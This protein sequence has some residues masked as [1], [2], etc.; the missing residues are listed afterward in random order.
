MEEEKD[1]SIYNQDLALE[2]KTFSKKIYNYFYMML[3]DK[4]ETNFLEIYILFIL[5]T[6]QLISYGISEP[7]L[8]V[9]K[10][11]SST[12]KTVSDVVGI[13]RISTLMKYVDF[14][15]YLII[16]FILIA[17]IFIFSVF[18]IMQIFI[19]KEESKIF[20]A[21]VT[22][23]RILI[24]PLYIF[25]F[26]PITE[27]ILLPL[28]C[29][30]EGKIDIIKDGITCWGGMHYL[31]IILGIIAS[32]IFFITIYFLISF[33]FFPFNYNES[34]IRINTENDTFFLIIKLIFALR[35]ILIKNE[36]ISI[37]LLF[38]LSLYNLFEEFFEA[39]FNNFKLGLFVNIRNF[40]AFWTYFSLLIAKLLKNSQINGVIYFFCFGIP[41]TILCCYLLLKNQ[42]A[43]FDYTTS[44]FTTLNEYLNK[45]RFLIQLIDSFIEGSKNIRFG[46]ESSNQKT[47][48]LLK[49]IIKIHTISCIRE[50]CPLTKFIQNPGNYNVQ[51]QCLLNYMTIYFNQGIKK[52]PFSSKLLLFFIQFNFSKRFNLNSVRTNIA[53]VQK[54][55]NTY[56]VDFIIYIL[57][58]DIKN[59]RIQISD[60][61]E[62]NN[63][64]QEMDA[65]T[66]KYRRLKYLIE[67]STKLYGEFWGIFATNIT[68][69]LNTF[70]L[71]NLGQKLNLYLKEINHL[72]DNELKSKKIDSENQGIIQL[73]S[74]FLKEILWNKK[75]SEEITKKLNDEHQHHHDNKKRIEENAQGNN[76]DADLENPDYIIYATSNEKGECTIGQCTNSIINLLG[77][78]KSEIIG[79]KIEVL[80]PKIFAEGHTKMLSDTIKKLHLKQHSQRNS[81][82]E[83]DKKNVFLVCKT[84]MGYL[85]PLSSKF[86][87]YEDND[88]SNSFIIKSQMEAK[89]TKSIYAYYIL[90]KNDF[91][92][93]SISS[94]AINLG[95]SMDLLNKYVIQLN[96][97]VR[98]GNYEK[99]NFLEKLSEF[100]EEPKEIM[101]IYPDLIY[102]KN[103]ANKNK[104][105]NIQ[106]LIN[107]SYKKKFGLQISVMKYNDEEIIGYVF[108]FVEMTKKNKEKEISPKDFVPNGNK[109]IIFDLLSLNY[110]RTIL[111]T[112]KSG[113]RNL[114]EKDDSSDND[115]IIRKSTGE[116]GRKK[117]ESNLEEVQES[118]E[119]DKKI[120]IVLNK[121]KILELQTKEIKDVENFI[122]LLPYFGA[123]ISLERHRPNKERYPVGRGHEPLIKIELGHFTKKIEEK[124]RA[125]PDLMKRLRGKDSEGNGPNAGV[126]EQK[127]D[128][129]YNHEFSSDTSTSLS[130]IFNSK[131]VVCMKI[132]SGF[133]F[134][135]MVLVVTV[136]FI[137]TFLN[138]QK[139]KDHVDIMNKSYTLLDN[140]GY[141]K[142]FITEAILCNE[143]ENYTILQKRSIEKQE[144]ITHIKGE[145]ANY[146]QE[147]SDIYGEFSSSSIKSFSKEYQ[148]YVQKNITV[149]T[150]SNGNEMTEDQVYSTAMNRIPTTAFYVSTISDK[151]LVLNMKERNCFELMQNL[152]NGYFVALKD[153]TK[154]LVKDAIKSSKNNLISTILFIATFAFSFLFLLIIWKILNSFFQDR[155]K[156][157]NLFLTIKKKIFEDLKNA[158]ESFSNKLLNKFFG[159]ED[160]EEESQKD[161]Q[162]NIKISDINIIK[163]K[164]PNEYKAVGKKNR[165]HLGN[166]IKLIFFFIFIEAYMIFKFCFSTL[167]INN[168]KKYIDVLNFTQYSHVDTISSVDVLKSYLFNRSIPIFN[169]LVNDT[170]NFETPYYYCFYNLTKK[171]EDMFISTSKTDCF[172]K[173]DYKETTFSQ[174][175]YHDFSRMFPLD[176]EYLNQ[177]IISLFQNGFKPIIFNIFEKLRFF[178][179]KANENINEDKEE[180]IIILNNEK[181]ADLDYLLTYV[182]RDWYNN[183][184]IIMNNSVEHYMSNSKLVQIT[185]YIVIMVI[186]I[187]AYCIIWKSYEEQL[188]L[189]LKRSFD[190]INLIPEEIKYLIVTKLNE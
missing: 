57:S 41:V 60:S 59:M 119:E 143:I 91:S 22:I 58:Q 134:F 129:D 8:D 104:N 90:T 52:F 155:E 78:M 142:Y 146:R 9:W 24:Y 46:S 180:T 88:F 117:N 108:K 128:N 183:L 51:K 100:E 175:L 12:L 84:K 172:L 81:Y 11:K 86:T 137:C 125:N 190:L 185:V 89:D 93:D 153:I 162:T 130:N 139:I 171:L 15:V 66:Q 14:N 85:I 19:G 152:L 95:I 101:W 144:Y 16:F 107:R 156:P 76:V 114:R 83:N 174:Y 35:F 69:N 147:F 68:N 7:H 47:D 160:N 67:N 173:G 103:E 34:S 39:T 168:I 118:S 110:I 2:D 87:I 154:I 49:G 182:V 170:N 116:K 33:Y 55:N 112:K 135:S 136:E 186:L 27:L 53:L 105:D 99:I 179:L 32:I 163:F 122:N 48:I 166:F 20:L 177:N 4:K 188:S 167:N 40:L 45:T 38:F 140:I 10:V 82:R 77:Y 141:S 74:R 64:E 18:L 80:M 21:S 123:D 36:Y 73:Y 23:T 13:F 61:N 181:W 5:E 43:N 63:L 26:I 29:N 65:L 70:K 132:I 31:Y 28:K 92:V 17:F 96:N 189:L 176:K 115:K 150:L 159:N 131:S 42:E 165:E 151:S 138:L 1:K 30:E 126:G 79:K 97:L 120:D 158:S 169:I 124:I 62:S 157:I 106:D 50:D 102:P 149:R 72:W 164:A 148:E 75:K 71:Y 111:V 3:K 98:N 6:I 25:F 121:E 94:S 145:L 187:L 161:Y 178:W 127:P 54:H 184:I 113:H 44:G 133:L 37:V 109:E 56:I